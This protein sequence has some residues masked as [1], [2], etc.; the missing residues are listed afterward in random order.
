M[1]K[2]DD[3]FGAG[4]AAEKLVDVVS[5]GIGR[6]YDDITSPKLEARRIKA[7]S[8][9]QTESEHKAVI[10]QTEALLEADK[11]A[12]RAGRRLIVKEISRQNNI[13]RI[14]FLASSEL[15]DDN[16]VSDEPVSVDWATRFFE[17]VQDVSKEEVQILWSKILTGEI[18]QP[19]SFSLRTLAILRNITDLEAKIFT[20]KVCPLVFSDE[21]SIIKIDG[22]NDLSDFN[23]NYASL[24]HMRDA[25]LVIDGDNI[26]NKLNKDDVLEFEYSDR[27]VAL[28]NNRNSFELPIFLLSAAGQELYAIQEFKTNTSYHDQVLDYLKRNGFVNPNEEV[29][30]EKPDKVV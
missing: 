2:L 20:D 22:N 5:K 4:K 26:V 11:L 30:E 3:I 15:N 12:Q 10:K 29:I 21:Q 24:L 13:E 25:G 7:I 28:K 9:A 27:K 18:K 6:I 8:A 19:G 23:F 17:V 14:I 16:D 1:D